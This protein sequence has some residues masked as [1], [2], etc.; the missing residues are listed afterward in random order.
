MIKDEVL[1]R[2]KD[3]EDYISGQELSDE[4]HVSR[5]AVWKAVQSIRQEGYEIEA[6]NKKGYRIRTMDEDVLNQTELESHLH[7]KWIGH[8]MIYKRQTGSTNDDIMALADQGAK[9]GVIVLSSMQTKGK[10]RRGR[11][12]ISPSEGNIYMSLL[13]RPQMRTDAV[14]GVT[15]VMALAVY[16]AV[17][18]YCRDIHKVRVGI[19]WPNDIVISVDGGPYKKITGILTEMRLEDTE[20]RDVTVGIGIN[21]NMEH[22]PEE[23]RKTATSLYL[24]LGEHVNRVRLIDTT[25]EYF[26]KDYELFLKTQDLSLLKEMYEEGLVNRGRKVL[27]LDPKGEY[28]GLA[29]GIDERGRLMVLPDGKDRPVAV[30]SGEISVRG[31]MGYV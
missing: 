10:G 30:E 12:W 28:Q 11:T 15:L 8:P 9:E 22:F 4:L 17:R 2:L 20:I 27:V 5:T 25:W 7:T 1:K 14:P 24:A 19:K 6:V 13:L 26:E 3:A 16:Q 31:V 21:I 18:E 29:G 23:I